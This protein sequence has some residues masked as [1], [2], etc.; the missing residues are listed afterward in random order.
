M[1]KNNFDEQLCFAVRIGDDSKFEDILATGK[2]SAAGI[3]RALY[4]AVIF[5]QDGFVTMLHHDG[6]D[7]AYQNGKIILAART[8]DMGAL[9]NAIDMGGDVRHLN[10]APLKEAV[11]NLQSQMA[12][13]L[14]D[15]HNADIFKAMNETEL[16]LLFNCRN[17]GAGDSDPHRIISLLSELRNKSVLNGGGNAPKFEATQRPNLRL[18]R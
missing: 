7:T 8:G 2:N 17:T 4:L 1:E 16:Q 11:M 14:V 15:Q 13:I 5:E 12:H 18:V 9:E 10:D 3:A 6:N